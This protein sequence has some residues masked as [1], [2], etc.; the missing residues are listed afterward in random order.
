[1]SGVRLADDDDVW[2]R[3]TLTS[4]RDWDDDTPSQDVLLDNV[5]LSE[6][7]SPEILKDSLLLNSVHCADVFVDRVTDVG[8]RSVIG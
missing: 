4:D 1:V 3:S 2:F 6:R 5:W 8:A 7:P